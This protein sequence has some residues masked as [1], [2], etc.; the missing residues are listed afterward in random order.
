MRCLLIVAP[1]QIIAIGGVIVS[2]IDLLYLIKANLH[3]RELVSF[4]VLR[5]I[6]STVD[7]LDY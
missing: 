2:V 4:S 5:G 3:L 7:L 1:R 6:L